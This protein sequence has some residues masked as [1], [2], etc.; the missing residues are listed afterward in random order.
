MRIRVQERWA[1]RRARP[2][3][4]LC[5]R[6]SQAIGLP[7]APPGSA[8]VHLSTGLLSPTACRPRA[9]TGRSVTQRILAGMST[10]QPLWKTWVRVATFVT[11]TV[12]AVVAASAWPTGATAVAA[13]YPAGM[14]AD[15][16]VAAALQIPDWRPMRVIA[17]LFPVVLLAPDPG[18]STGHVWRAAQ[19]WMVLAA[20][21][22]YGCT[23]PDTKAD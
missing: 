22:A 19:I 12:L 20:H 16:A 21:R 6:R 10:P 11:G 23:P 13:V 9:L 2:R 15:A 7:L 1:Y 18:A 17:G 3:R 4:P 5:S 14:T 8:S